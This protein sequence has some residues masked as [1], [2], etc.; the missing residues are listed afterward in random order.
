[1]KNS[2]LVFNK[3][4]GTRNHDH[5]VQFQHKMTQHDFF[6]AP[7][8]VDLFASEKCQESYAADPQRVRERL[9]RI[10]AE[11]K[12]A[13]VLPCDKQ[14]LGYYRTVVPQMSLWLPADEASQL[15]FQFAEEVKRLELAS[16][17]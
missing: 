10:I 15:R 12:A 8:Q 6:Q 4:F 5:I 13:D 3:A 1:M 9:H 14:K 17:A 16:S 11:A 2:G 7:K